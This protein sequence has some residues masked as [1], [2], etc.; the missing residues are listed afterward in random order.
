MLSCVS[1][2]SRKY[3][4]SSQPDILVYYFFLTL[5]FPQFPYKHRYGSRAKRLK[6]LIEMRGLKLNS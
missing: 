2:V 4:C 6:P 3:R 1:R 5:L